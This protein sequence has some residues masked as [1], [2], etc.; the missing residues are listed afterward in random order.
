M[1]PVRDFFSPVCYPI[2]SGGLDR[3]GSGEM[4]DQIIVTIGRE[5]GSGGHYIAA[6]LARRLG[7]QLYDREILEGVIESS[8]YSRELVDQMDEKPVNLLFSRR[9]GEFSNSLEANVAE[10]TF[11]LIRRKAE[12]GES[13]V[14]V[15]RCA[16][17]VLRGNPNTVRL[18]IYGDKAFKIRRLMETDGLSEADAA[19]AMKQTDR[20][21]R[22]YHN[23][24]CDDKWGDCRGYD[25]AVNSGLVGVEESAEALLRYIRAFQEQRPPQN[26]PC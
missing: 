18:F 23:Y 9:I 17:Q 6:I 12:R 22:A 20:E 24:Y 11:E 7:I 14:V 3:K 5:H 8:G 19:A 13:F 25:I 16:E 1:S 26:E 15:G 21:R 4:K 2:N 10:K